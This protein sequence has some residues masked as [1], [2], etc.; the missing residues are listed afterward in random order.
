MQEAE[1]DKNQGVENHPENLPT[2]PNYSRF[3][4]GEVTRSLR[5]FTIHQG[6]WGAWSQMAGLSTAVMTGYALWLGCLLYTSPS[7]RD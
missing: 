7:P 5:A 1:V 3:S 4:R 6:L 2:S